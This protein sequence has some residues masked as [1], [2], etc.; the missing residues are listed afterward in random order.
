[1]EVNNILNPFKSGSHQLHDTETALLK[2]TNDILMNVD[3]GHHSIFVLL[4]LSV[5]FDTMIILSY[6][7]D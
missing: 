7:V 4:D 3:C 6:W 1:M 5:A 2:V